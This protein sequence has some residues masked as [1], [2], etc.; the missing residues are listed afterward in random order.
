MS[1]IAGPVLNIDDRPAQARSTLPYPRK[2]NDWEFIR[3]HKPCFKNIGQ[4]LLVS[5]MKKLQ[6]RGFFSIS[7]T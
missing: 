7:L 6:E 1:C 2:D 3:E 4:H 5:K